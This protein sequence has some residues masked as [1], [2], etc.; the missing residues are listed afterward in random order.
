MIDLPK[1]N[2]NKLNG[3]K[4]EHPDALYE[5]FLELSRSNKELDDYASMAAHDLK[6]PARRIS[7][8]A[9]KLKSEAVSPK[10][11]AYIGAIIRSSR[12]MAIMIDDLLNVARVTSEAHKRERVL[13]QK[14]TG[15]VASDL[16]TAVLESGA[17][18][19]R[20]NLPEIVANRVQI[21]QLFQNLVENAIKYRKKTEPPRIQIVGDVKS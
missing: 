11:V 14:L 4:L 19:E 3:N 18:I 1:T 10:S 8:F 2:G 21:Y 6:A 9:E 20:A 13:L 5:A 16:E 7:L 17:V 12:L 15:E